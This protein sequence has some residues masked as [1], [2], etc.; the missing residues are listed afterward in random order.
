MSLLKS[1][2]FEA[3]TIQPRKLA[4]VITLL[5]SFYSLARVGI[6]FFESI[7]IVREE[8]LQDAELLSLCARG[9]ARSSAKMRDAC[10]KAR[11]DSSAPVFFKAVSLAVSTAFKDFV[12]SVGS[13]LKLALVATFLLSGV[14][15]PQLPLLRLFLGQ[16]TTPQ[17]A[18]DGQQHLIFIGNA[19]STRRSWKKRL[20][21]KRGP[22]IEELTEL[23]NGAHLHED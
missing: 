12:D 22:Q 19:P 8:R 1:N 15:L 14:V 23:E 11:A 10:L 3:R 4:A 16:A 13:P 5:V 21:F 9:D 2:F 7:A 18:G 20:G 6:L 17:L